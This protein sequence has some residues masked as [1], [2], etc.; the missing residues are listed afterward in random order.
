MTKIFIIPGLGNSGPEHWQT[1]FEKQLPGTVRID[2]KEWD[3]PVCED[4]IATINNALKDVDPATVILVGHSL[5][6]VTIAR[7]AEQAKAPIKGAML[8]APSDIESPVYEFPATG[9]TPIPS[10]P[11]PFPTIVVT[12]DDDHW[13]S[14]DRAKFFAERWGSELVNIGNAGHINAVAGY[15]PWP[16]G[17]KLLNRLL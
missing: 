12:S 6:C 14:L 3:A 8:V 7:W 5:G 11:I 16:E 1:W 4:W 10:T 15:G 17:L 2:Q 13:V 9:F